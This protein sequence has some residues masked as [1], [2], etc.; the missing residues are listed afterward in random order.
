MNDFMYDNSGLIDNLINNNRN[1]KELSHEENILI[2]DNKK[3]DTKSINIKELIKPYS[4]LELDLKNDNITSDTFFDIILINT[5]KVEKDNIVSPSLTNYA[6]DLLENNYK[7][8][9]YDVININHF[10]TLV[11]NL[12]SLNEIDYKNLNKFI[13]YIKLLL[14]QDNTNETYLNEE[15]TYTLNEFKNVMSNIGDETLKN[16]YNTL[17]NEAED[18]K[19]KRENKILR[20]EKKDGYA[21]ALLVVAIMV[22]TGIVIGTLGYFF[23]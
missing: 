6:L 5:I 3:I 8:E 20:L 15:Q 10:K 9:D 18:E 2:L 11:N 17:L 23:T 13:D 19:K 12:H 7:K 16:K 14:I 1:L 4:K 22:I 21:N